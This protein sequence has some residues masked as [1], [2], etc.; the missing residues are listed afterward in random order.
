MFDVKLD[1]SGLDNAL[2]QRGME[3]GGEVQRF[4]DSEV[5]RLCDPYVPM[6]TGTLKTSASVA[7]DIGSG[8]VVYETPYAR[9]MYYNP[10]L[11]F[12]GKDFT[13]GRGAFWAERMAADHLQDIV[14]GAAK[15]AGGKPG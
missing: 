4:V 13:P 10:D 9:T 2:E 7:T 3:P 15:I 8:E 14:D 1:L 5:I 11:N 6:D 12:Q